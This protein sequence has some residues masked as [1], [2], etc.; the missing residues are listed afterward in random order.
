MRVERF[1]SPVA[2][3]VGNRTEVVA[4]EDAGRVLEALD[5]RRSLD[6]NRA[7]S[8]IRRA[9]LVGLAERHNSTAVARID[10]PTGAA[11]LAVINSLQRGRALSIPLMALQTALREQFR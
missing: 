8:S 2:I 11:L 5:E 3:R 7:A 4:A 6:A 9:Q 10:A 1:V